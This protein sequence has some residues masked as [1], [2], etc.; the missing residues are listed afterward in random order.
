MLRAVLKKIQKA[1]SHFPSH[2]PIV[3]DEHDVLDTA[4]EAAMNK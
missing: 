1:A 2:I 4:G 3:K